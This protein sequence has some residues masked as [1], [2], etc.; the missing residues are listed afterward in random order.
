MQLDVA[1]LPADLAS[2]ETSVCIVIDALRASSSI[3]TVF[4]RGVESVAVAGTIEDA[5]RLH[6]DLPGSLLCGE[7]GGLPPDGFDFG[8]SPVEF[9][10]ADLRGRTLV[11][12]TSNG[13]RALAA[14]DTAP[15]VFVGSLL[16]RAACTAAALAAIDAIGSVSTMTVVCSGTEFGTTFSLED[17]VVAGAFVTWIM[18]SAAE[19]THELTDRAT[20]AA[21]LWR[22]YESD[23]KQAFL[24]AK[25][26]RYLA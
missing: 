19:E 6:G 22:G 7:S 26:G 15:V 10:A 11:L 16:N 2:P 17:T 20:A 23:P 12:A 8:N 24:E 1:F 4:G 3:A 14:L 9:A 13:T 18:T 25:H 21:R 5:R